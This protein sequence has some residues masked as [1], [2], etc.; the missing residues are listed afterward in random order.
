MVVTKGALG[1][2]NTRYAQGGLAAAVGPDDNPDLHFAD[3][4]VA[5]AGLCDAPAVRTLVDEG[6]AAIQWLVAHGTVFDKVGQDGDEHM[7]ALGKEAAH[8]R[9]RVLHAGGDATGA[10]IERSLVRQL[11][12]RHSTS[13]MEHTTAIDLVTDSGE[14]CRGV[15]V[16][17][18]GSSRTLL[19][20]PIMVLANGGAGQLWAVS[21]NPPG[22]TGDGIAMAFRAGVA[23]ADLEF[24][25]F[26]PTVLAADGLE[27]F[28]VS[29]AV[30]GEG[31]YLR[32]TSGERFMTAIHPMAELAPRDVVARAIQAQISNPNAGRVFLDLRHL[33]RDLIR[34]RFPSISGRLESHGIDLAKDLIPVAPAAHY[35]MGGIVA[36]TNGRTS[37]PGLLAIGEVSCTGVHGA[38]RLASNSLLEGLVFGLRAADLAAMSLNGLTGEDVDGEFALEA[39]PEASGEFSRMSSSAASR[40]GDFDSIRTE[41]QETMSRNVAVVRDARSLHEALTH[42]ESLSPEGVPVAG[43]IPEAELRNVLLLARE[44]TRSALVREES[45]GGHYRA[46][47][48]EQSPALAGQHLLVERTA[49]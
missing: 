16:Q 49:N 10:E 15:I 37:M 27:P 30:R 9:N 40:T 19:A 29:E 13:V 3:T 44:V 45:R 33:E 26:H 20:A 36:D 12:N 47:F 4:I 8:S 2:S 7:L 6:A 5:G 17:S 46:D 41:V 23:V 22:A 28:L 42:L 34:H 21:S 38:N 48:P 24:T 18:N 39:S 43:S 11:R 35:F 31:A 14:T 1:E 32:S 25:Q